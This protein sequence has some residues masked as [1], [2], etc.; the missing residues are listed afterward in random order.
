MRKKN[1]FNKPVVYRNN[2]QG[3]AF[4]SQFRVKFVAPRDIFQYKSF[5][6]VQTKNKKL[7]YLIHL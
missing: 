3:K 2:I 6:L 7:I 4:P 5:H 1:Y